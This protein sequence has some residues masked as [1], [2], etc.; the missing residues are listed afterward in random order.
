VSDDSKDTVRE[1]AGS[2]LKALGN[3][4]L[5]IC[6]PSKTEHDS[7]AWAIETILPYICKKVLTEKGKLIFEKIKPNFR[8][9]CFF[10]GGILCSRE[11]R[12]SC[13]KS[14]KSEAFPW[15]LSATS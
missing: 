9:L 11:L 3:V 1:A 4:S 14:R 12:G 2:A 6:D 13:P 5:R 7:A 8:I 10:F 15:I